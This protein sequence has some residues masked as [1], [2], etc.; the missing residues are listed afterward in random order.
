[1]RSFRA[2]DPDEEEVRTYAR[3][4]RC[5][6]EKSRRNAHGGGGAIGLV[7]NAGLGPRDATELVRFAV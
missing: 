6:E 5:D 3:R 1:V 2:R 4:T 7:S